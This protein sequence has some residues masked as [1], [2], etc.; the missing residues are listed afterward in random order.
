MK[1]LSLLL[2]SLCITLSGF[3]QS[4]VSLDNQWNVNF[5]SFD[6]ST[7]GY[8]SSTDIY[9]FEEEVEMEGQNYLSLAQT[10]DTTLASTGLLGVL[11]REEDGRVYQRYES[12]GPERL[13]YDFNLEV[14][15]EFNVAGEYYIEV[16]EIDSIE[17]LDNSFRKVLKVQNVDLP[18]DLYTYWIEGIGDIQS[19][20][21]PERSFI[22]DAEFRLACF[23]EQG[24][25]LFENVDEPCF[26]VTSTDEINATSG[27]KL[28]PNPTAN[29]LFLDWSGTPNGRI[30]VL[31]S[32]GQ[33]VQSQAFSTELDVSSLQ[34]GLYFLRVISPIG[35]LVAIERFLKL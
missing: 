15:D 25:H 30:E 4:F 34:K 18:I 24:V 2:G 7:G 19:T 12:G 17:L 21:F 14:G 23:Y 9:I 3:G 20:L 26:F 10:T 33:V 27:L 5:Y 6:F 35:E 31:N 28:Y 29:Q 11:Y 1:P 22:L 13:I 16:L 32:V 8:F